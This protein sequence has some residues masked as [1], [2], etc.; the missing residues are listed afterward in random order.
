VADDLRDRILDHVVV[1]DAPLR[2][3]RGRADCGRRPSDI[4][5]RTVEENLWQRAG[6]ARI[7]QGESK[8]DAIVSEAHLV[9]QARREDVR[10][11]EQKVVERGCKVG[12]EAGE[13]RACAAEGLLLRVGQE[14]RGELIALA[15]LMINAQ[16]KLPLIEDGR[17]VLNERTKLD[18]R[19]IAGRCGTGGG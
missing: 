7:M 11:R 6:D 17:E 16:L 3:R 18:A 13:A 19:A 1:G 5:R 15:E 9:R 14:A 10:L 12:L 4:R 8:A 2:E